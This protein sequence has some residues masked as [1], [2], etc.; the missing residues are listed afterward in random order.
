MS[1]ESKLVKVTYPSPGVALV[2]LNRNVTAAMSTLK[3]STAATDPARRARELRQHVVEF[4]SSI[5][6]IEEVPQPVIGAVHGYA[7][8][9]AIDILCA[10][11]IR[12]ASTSAIFSIK[13]IDVGL[14]A[15]IGTLARIPKI[16]GNQSAIRE[17]ALTT[18]NFGAEEALQWGFVSK[19]L[20][21]GQEEVIKAALETATII[22]S[23]SPVAVVGT[24]HLLLHARDHSVRENLEYT[25][26]WNAANLQTED[27]AN[28]IAAF[29]TKAGP[30]FKAL[31]KL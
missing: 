6:A 16:T 11:D 3:P 17:L 7:L 30:K 31:P 13:E 22:A 15:D 10:C 19:V 28:A 9:L 4:Q 24:K 18:R 20:K 23:K 25:A 8:G 26:T 21:G 27:M 14:A 12:Y 1:T 5:S 29:K 2:I